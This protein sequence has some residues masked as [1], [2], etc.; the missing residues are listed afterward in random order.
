MDAQTKGGNDTSDFRE[1]PGADS[2]KSKSGGIF[3]DGRTTECFKR[4]INKQYAVKKRW[5]GN[6]ENQVCVCAASTNL[7]CAKSRA[8][9]VEEVVNLGAEKGSYEEIGTKALKVRRANVMGQIQPGIP[10]WKTGR[11]SR[12][13]DIPYVIFPGN[14][15]EDDTLRKVADILMEG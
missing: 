14:V 15:G 11:E 5:S 13:P 8:E 7:I 3:F 1:Q 9:T 6:E 10:V 2:G 12:F 4:C